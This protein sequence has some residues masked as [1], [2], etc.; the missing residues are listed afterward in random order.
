MMATIP[1][2]DV[3]RITVEE[4]AARYGRPGVLFVDVRDPEDYA[5]GHIT[6]AIA[7]PLRDIPRR[8]HELPRTAEIIL[9]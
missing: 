7:M 5:A 2:P 3:E 1:Y 8:Y 4:A 6:G 9:Y